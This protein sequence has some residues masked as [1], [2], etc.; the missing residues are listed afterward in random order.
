MKIGTDVQEI[1]RFHLRYMKGCNV[2][3]TDGIFVNYAIGICSDAMIYLPSFIMTGSGIQ[4]FIERLH[5]QTH[6]EKGNI[7]KFTLISLKIK[8]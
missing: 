1:L 5:I 3:I 6:R 4:N 7:I 8:K 2:D